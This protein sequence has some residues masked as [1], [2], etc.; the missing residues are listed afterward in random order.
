MNILLFS[1][2]MAYSDAFFGQGSGPIYF[3]NFACIGSESSL[4]NCTNSGVNVITGCR[5]H[6]DDA[7]VRCAQGM[8]LLEIS[9]NIIVGKKSSIIE[10]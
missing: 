8:T 2:A 5:G 4:V 6:L 7:G 3:N 10:V 1:G 9:S